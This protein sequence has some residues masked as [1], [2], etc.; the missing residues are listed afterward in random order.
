M[1]SHYQDPIR[2]R[3]FRRMGDFPRQILANCK[4]S[5]G[6]TDVPIDLSLDFQNVLARVGRRANN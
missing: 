1:R 3:D 4:L 6:E 5:E 2:R